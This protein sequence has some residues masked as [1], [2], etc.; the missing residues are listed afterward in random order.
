M[1]WTL[2]SDMLS[3][4][5]FLAERSE[6]I[7]RGCWRISWIGS[8]FL[9]VNVGSDHRLHRLRW[10]GGGCHECDLGLEEVVG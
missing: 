7:G 5:F 8:V 6:A 3:L 4:F 2:S 9:N 1:T 10:R